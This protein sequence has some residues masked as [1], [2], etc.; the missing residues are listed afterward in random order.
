MIVRSGTPPKPTSTTLAS[1]NISTR[2]SYSFVIECSF[3]SET[4]EA[5]VACKHVEVGGNS[6]DVQVIYTSLDYLYE[7]YSS[8]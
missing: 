1:L 7:I 6:E 5:Q 2:P 8:L 3:W 4:E